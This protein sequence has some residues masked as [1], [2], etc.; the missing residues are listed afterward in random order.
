MKINQAWPMTR[1]VLSV[2][3][4]SAIALGCSQSQVAAPPASLVA[5]SVAPQAAAEPGNAADILQRMATFLANTSQFTVNLTDNF[6]VLQASGQKIEFGETRKITLSRPNG[7]RVELEESN[8][9]KHTVLYDGKDI[10][11]FS[12][13]Q[14]VYAQIA[15]PGGVDDAVKYFLKELHMRLPLAALLLSSFPAEITARTESLDY[16]ERT[17]IQGVPTHHLAGRTATVDYQVWVAEGAQPL[18][19]RAVL[20]YKNAEGQPQ[21]SAQFSDWNLNPQIQEA[22]FAFTP[23]AGVRKIA[24]QAE[25]SKITPKEGSAS[26]QTGE[27]Q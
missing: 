6:D 23:P 1:S 9:D 11:V 8:G 10:T 3:I 21:F 4:L 16:V 24:F 25:L 17:L 20:T 22:Q 7:L 5:Q 19:V 13:T 27:Q 15:K 18:P 2:S 26:A 14:N 12:P